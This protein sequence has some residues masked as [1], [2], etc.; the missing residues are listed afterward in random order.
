[1]GIGISSERKHEHLTF[2]KSNLGKTSMREIARQ[3]NIGRTTVNNWAKEL[4]FRHK[5]HTINEEFFNEFNEHSAYL[6]GLIYADGSVTWNS[7]KGYQSLTI[8][9][10][11]KDKD[12]LEYLR[13]LLSSTKPLLYSEKTN[14]YRLI[15]NSKR[16]CLKLMEL[17]VI[18]RKSLTIEFPKFIPK[19]HLHH[20]IRGITDGDGNVRYVKRKRSSY[21]EITISSGSLN[22]CK[23][24]IEAIKDTINV[25]ANI[26]KIGTNTY[27]IQYS[28]SRGEQLAEFLYSNSNIYLKRKHKEYKKLLEARKK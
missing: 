13:N 21:F 18:P 9:A 6:L 8:T 4:G 16:L 12:H 5:K 7:N 23:G 22:F 26:R 2:I 15:A 24:L 14:S 1:M 19:E 28:C 20:F 27:I 17:G 11:A 3:L 10:S 25:D